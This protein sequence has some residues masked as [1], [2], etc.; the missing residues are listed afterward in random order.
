MGQINRVEPEDVTVLDTLHSV[1][2]AV[3]HHRPE[4]TAVRDDKDGAVRVLA[5]D[6]LERFE[7]APVH[8]LTR[9]AVPERAVR[10]LLGEALL[11]LRVAQAF[12]GAEVPLTQV[13][14]RRHLKAVR[15]GDDARRLAGPREVARVDR[16]ERLIRELLGQG[17]RLLAARV[18]KGPVGVTLES[19]AE[20]PVGLTVAHEE[21][22]RHAG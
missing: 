6:L 14:E 11:D 18:V 9:L 21:D 1:D 8:L 3:P 17:P 16:L 15:L 22:P 2:L 10:D 5:G 4:R 19:P 20:V 7:D 13:R 12:P